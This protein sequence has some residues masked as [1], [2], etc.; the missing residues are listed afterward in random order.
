MWNAGEGISDV[1]SDVET[2]LG[3]CRFSDCRHDKEPGCAISQAIGNGELAA[4]RWDSYMKLKRETLYVEDKAA[5]M[6]DRNARFKEISQWVKNR[7][8]ETW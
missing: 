6:R 5:A 4:E 3:Y 7:D 1:F 8:K 2:F